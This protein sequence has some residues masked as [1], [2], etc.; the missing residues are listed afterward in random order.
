MATSND[1]TIDYYDSE[2]NFRMVRAKSLDEAIK[3]HASLN[4]VTMRNQ[5]VG[6]ICDGS[7]RKYTG[8]GRRIWHD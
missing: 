8:D 1:F 5:S 7:G 4:S 2:G 3:T 6:L